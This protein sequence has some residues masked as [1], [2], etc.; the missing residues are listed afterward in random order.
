[1]FIERI[2]S[3]ESIHQPRKAE[4]F[5]AEIK[6]TTTSTAVT[7]EEE[8]RKAREEDEDTEREEKEETLASSED[9][10]PAETKTIPQAGRINVTA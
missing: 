1:M 4:K 9:E 5:T 7:F 6:K 10:L 2:Q 8:K 3:P